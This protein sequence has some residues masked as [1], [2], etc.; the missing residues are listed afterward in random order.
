MQVL[1]F[2]RAEQYNIINYDSRRENR[3]VGERVA[4]LYQQGVRVDE[5]EII[6]YS[7]NQGTPI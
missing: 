1:S 4:T 6:I 3:I 7:E 2:S 5:R